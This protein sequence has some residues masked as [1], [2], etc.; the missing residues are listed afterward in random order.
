MAERTTYDAEMTREELAEYLHSL[1]DE[2]NDE[3]GTVSIPLGNKRV[4]VSPSDSID[5]EVTVTERSRRLRKD[6][7]ELALTFSWHPDRDTAESGSGRGS[8]S[9]SA[10]GTDGESEDHNDR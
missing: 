2:L 5:S 6:T 7:E 9:G 10:S 8:E 4:R 1:A 3:G